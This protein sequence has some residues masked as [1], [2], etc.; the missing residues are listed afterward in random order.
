MPNPTTLAD[1]VEAP[2]IL[3]CVHFIGPDELHAMQNYGVAQVFAQRHNEWWQR[4]PRTEND[5]T[6]EQGWAKVIEW[7]YD[8]ASHAE[9][10]RKHGRTI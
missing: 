5:V 6:L 10:V 3:W 8:A 4:Q 1:R 9:E 2:A 7:P